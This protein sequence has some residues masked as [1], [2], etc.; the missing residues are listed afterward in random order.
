MKK[1]IIFLLLLLVGLYGYNTYQKIQ[2]F[3]FN[4][5]S[6][7]AIDIPQGSNPSLVEQYYKAIE[8]VNGYV[9]SQWS[10]HNID[11]RVPQ[12][13][14]EATKR[15]VEVYREKLGFTK[16]L[17]EKF[18]E[19]EN[20]LAENKKEKILLENKKAIKNIFKQSKRELRIGSS[21][22]LVYELQQALVKKGFSIK[23]DGLFKEETFLALKNFESQKG[24][25]PDGKLDF[26]TLEYLLR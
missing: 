19:K 18:K 12:E 14:D 4:N 22:V 20:L 9:I 13:K 6:Y 1:I 11:V 26:L 21:G 25:Y 8:D 5:Y 7:Q 15:A 24:L 2:R 17:E 10:L 16:Y 3:N 23:I